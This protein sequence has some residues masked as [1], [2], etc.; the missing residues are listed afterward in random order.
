MEKQLAR[1]GE[2]TKFPCDNRYLADGFALLDRG[3][4]TRTENMRYNLPG[5]KIGEYQ[6]D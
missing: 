6:T 5:Y 2:P 3:S 1:L 4:S